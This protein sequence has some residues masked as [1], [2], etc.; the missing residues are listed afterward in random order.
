MIRVR[1]VELL[2]C[3]HA[4]LKDKHKESSLLM[5]QKGKKGL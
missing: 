5:Q 3:E 1:L 2:E 4:E